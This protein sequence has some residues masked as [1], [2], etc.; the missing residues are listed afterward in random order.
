MRREIKRRSPKIGESIDAWSE[1]L[2]GCT[3]HSACSE[4]LQP[5]DT[6]CSDHTFADLWICISSEFDSNLK[7]IYINKD[8]IREL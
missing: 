2:I 8:G 4:C 3:M 6:F 5:S 1:E 7:E